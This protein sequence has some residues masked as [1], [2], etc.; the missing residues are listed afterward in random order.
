MSIETPI[1]P[2]AFGFAF[3][4]VN[5]GPKGSTGTINS[6]SV[7][8]QLL[9]IREYVRLF[10]AQLEA[11]RVATTTY[12]AKS[13]VDTEEFKLIVEMASACSGVI[14]VYDVFDMLRTMTAGRFVEVAERLDNLPVPLL[15]VSDGRRWNSY[16]AV[17]RSTSYRQSARE[18]A[19]RSVRIKT[20]LKEA[21]RSSLPR[22]PRA[23]PSARRVSQADLRARRLAPTLVTMIAGA[24]DPGMVSA[25]WLAVQ[26]NARGELSPT[27]KTWSRPSAKNLLERCRSLR[28]MD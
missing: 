25:T 14:F 27:G 24:S 28:L 7:K 6:G 5:K 9:S 13:F 8:R 18:L 11:A 26:L 22:T 1:P 12:R 23:R 16:S 15:S 17:E 20:G 2:P 21:P 10:G 4:Y 19:L 3:D